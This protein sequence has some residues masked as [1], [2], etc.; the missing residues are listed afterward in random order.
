MSGFFDR[1]WKGSKGWFK[2]WA[3]STVGNKAFMDSTQNVYPER[4]EEEPILVR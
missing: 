2:L 1:V 4:T 3:S